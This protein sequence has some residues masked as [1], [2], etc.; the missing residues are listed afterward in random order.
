MKNV[1]TSF[2]VSVKSG[3]KSV[4][5]QFPFSFGL[6]LVLKVVLLKLGTYVNG[7]FKFS[8]DISNVLSTCTQGAGNCVAVDVLLGSCNNLIAG[9]LDQDHK[10]RRSVIEF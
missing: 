3:E 2:R 7:G 10:T 6:V 5:S 8:A 4:E 9:H 1:V